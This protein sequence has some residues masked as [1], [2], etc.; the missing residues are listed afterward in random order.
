MVK[1]SGLLYLGGSNF[2]WIL[3]IVSWLLRTFSMIKCSYGYAS[4]R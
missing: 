4:A 2:Y 1:F 3:V